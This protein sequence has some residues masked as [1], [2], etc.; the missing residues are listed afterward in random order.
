MT[1]VMEAVRYILIGVLL[2]YF[3]WWAIERWENALHS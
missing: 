3:L 2:G 1:Y